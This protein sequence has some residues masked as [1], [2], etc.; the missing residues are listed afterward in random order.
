M[1]AAAKLAFEIALPIE[2]SGTHVLPLPSR[3]EH[4]V[5]KLFERAVGGFYKV[6]LPSQNWRV[7]T[8]HTLSW[9]IDWKSPG[10]DKILPGMR[11]DIV[12]DH[13]ET[14]RRIVV[15]TKFS[16]VLTSGWYREESLRSGYLYQLYAY[17]RSQVGQGDPFA[18]GAE[19]V[20]LH[21][22]IGERVD[23]T[24][25]IQGHRIRIMTVDLTATASEIRMELLRVANPC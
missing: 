8:G 3:E 1:I 9:Q 21:P 24:V 16:T 12:L 7:S 19:G 6:V 13:R 23:E 22:S 15:D 14:S 4:W 20:L 18:D 17:L 10:I 2:A 11:T 5:R 25:V